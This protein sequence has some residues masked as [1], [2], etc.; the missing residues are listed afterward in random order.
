MEELRIKC[1]SCSIILDVRN[2]KNETVKQI[3]CPNC[4]KNLAITFREEQETPISI[5]MFHYGDAA[6]SLKEGLNII[7]RKHPES[8][9]DIQIATGD[10]DMELE[11]ASIN[12]VR[13]KNGT[14]KT[15][16]KKS[17]SKAFVLV[18]TQELQDDDELVFSK[19][20]KI[21]MGDTIIIYQ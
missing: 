4:K 3:V 15:I 19:G 9:A 14:C 18:G 1:P 20:D 10:L 13:L 17:S 7:G 21:Q 6:Y 2:S 5:G 16:I 11:H 8:Q 12:V